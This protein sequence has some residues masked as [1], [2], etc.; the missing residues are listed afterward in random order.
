MISDYNRIMLINLLSTTA[1][2]SQNIREVVFVV[3]IFLTITLIIWMR[4]VQRRSRLSW[5]LASKVMVGGS[6]IAIICAVVEVRYA[7]NL[8][9]IQ[10]QQADLYLRY[11]TL[12]RQLNNLS[13]SMIE[14][15][16]KY[17]VAALFLLDGQKKRRMSDAI[18]YMI[19]I[20]L[21][22]ALIEDLIYFFNPSTDPIYR[23]LSFY[24]HSGTSAIIGY[25]IGRFWYGLTN[26]ADVLRSVA[27]AILLHFAYNVATSL[28]IQPLGFILTLAITVYITYQVFI[29]FRRTVEEEYEM[30]HQIRPR[31]KTSRLLN[32]RHNPV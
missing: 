24:L 7:F 31:R 28:E 29:L 27:G 1:T 15:L 3:E 11:G 17:F 19:I 8:S 18:L 12:Y 23:L 10:T 6:V 16:G 26:Y 25:S 2:Y 30:E 22:F 9:N 5:S 13:A 21:G 4:Q 32:L 20:G 14:E